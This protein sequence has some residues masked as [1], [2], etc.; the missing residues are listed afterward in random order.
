MS[1]QQVVIQYNLLQ[2]NDVENRKDLKVEQ[3]ADFT[4]EFLRSNSAKF[5]TVVTIPR[6]DEEDDRLSV[7]ELEIKYEDLYRLLC[8]SECADDAELEMVLNRL[9]RRKEIEFD[10]TNSV[11]KVMI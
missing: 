10:R 5:G 6:F 1:H 11:F 3:R 4:I 2:S 9:Y 7:K 8:V